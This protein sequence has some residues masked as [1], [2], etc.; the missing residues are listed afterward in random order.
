M[1]LAAVQSSVASARSADFTNAEQDAVRGALQFLRLSC[2]GW[3]PLAKAL[4]VRGVFL[5]QVATGHRAV[6]PRLVVRIARFA[7]VGIDDLLAGQFPSPGTCPY[8][9]HVKAEQRHA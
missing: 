7:R 8:C 6:S 3:Q 4:R 2:R 1:T 9:G 5:S